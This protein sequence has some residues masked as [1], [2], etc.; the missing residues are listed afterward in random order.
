MAKLINLVKMDR[1]T[2]ERQRMFLDSHPAKQLA[3]P[4]NI[5]RKM[6]GHDSPKDPVSQPDLSEVRE[7]IL[8]NFGQSNSKKM[9]TWMAAKKQ[10]VEKFFAQ[11]NSAA[12]K[13]RSKR[14]R[15]A[16]FCT[17]EN[18]FTNFK[19]LAYHY[20]RFTVGTELFVIDSPLAE[21][22][23]PLQINK[24]GQVESSVTYIRTRFSTS[25]YSLTIRG[26]K[27]EI[28]FFIVPT[29]LVMAFSKIEDQLAPIV[30]VKVISDAK[31]I[32]WKVNDCWGDPQ[33]ETEDFAM[34]LFDQLID[35]SKAALAPQSV[36]KAKQFDNRKT[37]YIEEDMILPEQA[38]VEVDHLAAILD[39]LELGID[40]GSA[41]AA[42]TIQET[43]SEKINKHN[44]FETL[45]SSPP[46]LLTEPET[47]KALPNRSADSTLLP[48]SP[49]TADIA[50]SDFVECNDFNSSVSIARTDAGS[51]ATPHRSELYLLKKVE[52][53]PFDYRKAWG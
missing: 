18:L 38:T 11:N 13:A 49:A 48:E 47:Y 27:D 7:G 25:L 4:K 52:V 35:H 5:D 16:L 12:R 15:E 43:V 41:F 2:K 9:D 32:S 10:D 33:Q 34:W 39:P 29:S 20:N 46:G 21:V 44:N 3:L 28:E 42:F 40:N 26:S 37:G 14:E 36:R 30:T 22:M 50:M 8:A 1:Q 53:E 24:Y 19:R 23:E 45:N 17:L 6:F 31:Q 51:N